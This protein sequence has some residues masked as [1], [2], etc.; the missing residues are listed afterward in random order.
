[1]R[2]EIEA[3]MA[4]IVAEFTEPAGNA[5]RIRPA[6][7]PDPTTKDEHI[8][9]DLSELSGARTEFRGS[10][11]TRKF[12]VC[13]SEVMHRRMAT[14]PRIIVMGED[15]HRLRGGTNGATRG[16]AEVFPG[17]ILG[18]P[19]AEAAFM[20]L[21]GG[22][23][24]D[25]RFRPVVEFMYPDFLWVAADQV[26]NQAAKARHMFGG[27]AKAPLVLRTKVAIGTG[28]GSQHSMDPAGI[29]A[30][31]PGWRI[32]APSTPYDYVGLMNAALACDD[33]VLVLEHVAL[34][35]SEGEA[36][37]GDWDYVIPIGSA[38]TVRRG[39]AVT[40][41][42]YLNMVGQSI[43]AA[44]A[45]GVDAEVIDLRT[46]D[47]ASLDWATVEAS[48]KRTGALIVV[49]EGAQGPSWGG[50][51]A[52][53]AQRRLFDWLDAPVARVTG[54]EASP[55]ISKVLEHAARA[56]QADVEAALIATE[57]ERGRR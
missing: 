31:A 5:R 13:V 2:A 30:T 46:L 9:G 7:W 43:A 20:G 15:I 11:V 23:A 53:A 14:D 50:W 55:T 41:A 57:R 35:Q 8:R 3:A 39:S 33:P 12:I 18:T 19:I 54:G 27:T 25:G 1:M 29:F 32:V 45:A 36:P 47:R 10:I 42:T 51:F 24:M 34:Y 48:V 44:D 38:K 22:M 6:L 28:Y 49:E 16:L 4:D 40:V 52:D 21:A 56:T 26:F 17:R 37:D